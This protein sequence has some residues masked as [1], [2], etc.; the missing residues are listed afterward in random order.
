M[1][2]IFLLNNNNFCVS[3]RWHDQLLSWPAGQPRNAN[4]YTGIGRCWQNDDSVSIAGRR[5]CDDHTD[6]WFQ[7]W[8]G[9]VQ[10]SEISSV[11]SGRTDE[12]ST[13]LAMLLHEHGRHY[14]CGGLGR[15]GSNRNIQGWTVVHVES[16]CFCLRMIFALGFYYILSDHLFIGRWIGRIHFSGV[17]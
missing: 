15:S 4:T 3:F 11:G 13:V 1:M 5:S 9:D 6:D 16:K 2:I 10:K 12:H 14:L 17:S 8:T 7:R